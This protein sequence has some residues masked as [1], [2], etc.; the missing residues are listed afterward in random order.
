MKKLILKSKKESQNSPACR[1][2]TLFFRYIAYRLSQIL[3][4][5]TPPHFAGKQGIFCVN[6]HISALIH[7]FILIKQGIFCVADFFV[8][9]YHQ[10]SFKLLFLLYVLEKSSICLGGFF[11]LPKWQQTSFQTRI[12]ALRWLFVCNGYY[13]TLEP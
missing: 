9:C 1:S 6:F 12:F 3:I 8:M 10:E 7:G 13:F 2:F 11:F 4:Y 5:H